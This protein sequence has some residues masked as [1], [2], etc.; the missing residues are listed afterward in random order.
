MPLYHYYAISKEGKENRGKMTANNVI[1]LETRIKDLDCDLVDYKVIKDKKAGLGGKIK[2]KDMIMLCV[3]MEELERAGVPILDSLIDLRDTVENPKMRDLLSDLCQ[4]IKG[5][6]KLSNAL[7]KRKDVFDELFIGLIAAGEETGNL[8]EV[9]GHLSKHIKWANDFK[10]KIKKALAYPIVLLVVMT[11]VITL[12]MLF[13]VPQLVDFLQK[14]GFD[15]PFYTIALIATSEFFVNYWWAVVF[16]I[17]SI[18]AGL[19]LLYKRHEPFRK[20]MDRFIL[21]I[22][23]VGPVIQKINLARFVKFFSITF[24]SGL[25]VLEALEISGKV[26]TNR[27]IKESVESIKAN[28]SEG[29]RITEALAE[30]GNFPSLVVR[31]FKVG[32]E[33]GNMERALGNI[34]YFYEREIDDAVETMVSMIQPTLLVVMG[35]TLMWVIA[36]VFGPVYGSFS[37]MKF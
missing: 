11:A 16:G 2:P 4:Y 17:P 5:G 33:S 26:V 6:D 1:D 20:V 19:I 34:N 25:G 22:P 15:L 7:A 37:K 23:G 27:V 30:N 13:V 29:V 12:M 24:N 32:E 35:G 21:K 14:Q 31:M 9:F 28:I 18:A 3:H 8:S 10:R 36:A